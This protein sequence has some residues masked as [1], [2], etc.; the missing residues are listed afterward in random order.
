M[1]TDSLDHSNLTLL[2]DTDG[3][4]DS[5]SGPSSQEQPGS[6]VDMQQLTLEQVVVVVVNLHTFV[7]VL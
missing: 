4:V 7:C 6:V 5:S 2:S 3:Y 1:Q